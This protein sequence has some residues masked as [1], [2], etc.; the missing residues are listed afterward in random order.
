MSA[1]IAVDATAGST[2]LP[3]TSSL[4]NSLL[5]VVPVGMWAKAS[6]SWL[7]E[8][9]RKA[10]KRRRSVTQIVHISTG[11]PGKFVA[12]CDSRG[13]GAGA[14]HCTTAFKNAHGT[15][16]RELL[17]PWHPWFAHRIAVHEAIGKSNEVVFRC[18]LSGSDAGRA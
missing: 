8:L 18:T 3:F 11:L 4:A 16:F 5:L 10:G 12:V 2:S 9:A 7:S 17:Y 1:P 13:S 15:I 14:R 6:I